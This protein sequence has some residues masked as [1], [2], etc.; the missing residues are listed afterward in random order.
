M[1]EKLGFSRDQVISGLIGAW[2]TPIAE[3][4][5]HSVYAQSVKRTR[6]VSGNGEDAQ[7]WETEEIKS[8]NKLDALKE[9]AKIIGLHPS[10][11]AQPQ[12]APVITVN[13]GAI[14]SPALASQEPT[15][16]L[17]APRRA[18]RISRDVEAVTVAPLATTH[19]ERVEQETD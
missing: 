8:V 19:D 17:P 9:I 1:E 18:V 6:K 12:Q 7:E 15:A 2:T 10:S 11:T 13:V 3:I 14:F 4:D 5:E 16:V